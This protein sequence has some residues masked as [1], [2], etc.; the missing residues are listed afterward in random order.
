MGFWI[1]VCS[2]AKSDR[3]SAVSTGMYRAGPKGNYDVLQVLFSSF[4]R[5]SKNRV[6]I[7]GH[8][9]NQSFVFVSSQL[10]IRTGRVF[11]VRLH[12]WA[13]VGDEIRRQ[14]P[15]ESGPDHGR[16]GSVV[17]VGVVGDCVPAGLVMREFVV[18]RRRWH[19]WN[20]DRILYVDHFSDFEKVVVSGEEV[21]FRAKV[22]DRVT[23]TARSRWRFRILLIC[24]FNLSVFGHW[25][26]FCFG[27]GW[28]PLKA[29]SAG[30]IFF[31]LARKR[32]LYRF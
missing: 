15:V 5:R 14:N 21:L 2:V 3:M 25:N 6:F 17:V 24:F 22:P 29:G 9:A 12:M 10:D 20:R 32:D 23:T 18:D 19:F 13:A 1:G 11:P 31:I 28:F 8:L 30:L 7:P 16:R 4:Y 27:S 26:K